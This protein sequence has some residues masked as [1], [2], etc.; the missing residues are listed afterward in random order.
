[1]ENK[2][3]LHKDEL[4]QEAM[5]EFADKGFD[6]AS[7][8]QIIKRSGISKGSFYHHFNN[9]EELFLKVVERSADE[10]LAFISRWIEERGVDS[11]KL[12]LFETLELLMQGGIEF[13]LQHPE[14]SQ[15]LLSIMKNQELRSKAE[16][17]SPE[18]YDQVFD[19]L[20][21]EAINQGE[22]RSDLDPEF[23]TKIIQY[24]FMSFGEL[25]MDSYKDVLERTML[26][27]QTS[28]F[29]EFIKHGLKDPNASIDD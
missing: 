10:K 4:L 27:E 19:P 20:I 21:K 7:L 2:G 11:R 22:L 26:E 3:F 29:L 9:K 6:S 13:A 28:Q 16:G 25:L 24:S 14:L 18:Y 5:T 17:L 8:N 15:F 1:M 23:M 12:G